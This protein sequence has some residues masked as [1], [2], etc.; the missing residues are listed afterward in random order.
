MLLGTTK[1]KENAVKAKAFF[2]DLIFPI[3]CVGCGQDEVWL[4]SGCFSR[5]R[6]KEIQCC[7]ACKKESARGKNFAAIAARNM[8]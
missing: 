7:L 3:E 6:M 5:I 1:F 8:I 2:L 4:C